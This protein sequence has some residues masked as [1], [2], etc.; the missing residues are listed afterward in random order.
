MIA[1][2]N[3]RKNKNII[4]ACNERDFVPKKLQF[5]D[6]RVTELCGLE[7]ATISAPSA[8]R[9]CLAEGADMVQVYLQKGLPVGRSPYV[10]ARFF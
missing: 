6:I 1:A 9:P 2:S 10:A 3:L 5:G 8:Q 4:I 7:C